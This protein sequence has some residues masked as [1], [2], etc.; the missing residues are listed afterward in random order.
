MLVL[1]NVTKK[2]GEFTAVSHVQL[3]FQEGIYGL[4]SPNG[5]GKTTLLKMVA[6]LMGTTTGNIYWN[7]Q[8]ILELGE[9]YREKIGYMPQ[10]FGYY[11]NYTAT[12]YLR[13]IAALKGM[14]RKQAAAEIQELLEKVGLGEV[15]GKK[16]KTFSGGMIQRVG[17][18]QAMLNSPELLILDE[19]TAGLD[20][21]ERARF[22][23]MLTSF[24]KGR[25]VLYSTHIVSDIE[26]IANRVIMLK[27]HRLYCDS[28]VEE[29][30]HRLEGKIFS[31]Y[32]DEGEYEDFSKE[33][34]VL[35]VKTEQGRRLVRFVAEEK[36]NAGGSSLWKP[37]CPNLEDV[38]LELYDT[39]TSVCK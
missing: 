33:H 28:T 34:F 21:K 22:R 7:G 9:K 20:P 30:C 26:N 29:L 17:I 2:Y 35:A 14:E 13:Y 39:R 1:E 5:A 36:E 10:H 12:A 23:E 18:V 37:E 19:P 38:F 31:T 32:V 15:S 4:L 6:T 11:P 24:A 16:L 27:D 25:I 3:E 8:N